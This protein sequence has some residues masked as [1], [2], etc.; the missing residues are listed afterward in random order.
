VDRSWGIT[1]TDRGHG[2]SGPGGQDRSDDAVVAAAPAEVVVER[3]AH[4]VFVGVG[5]IT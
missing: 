4:G 2:G 3:G 5:S 1:G